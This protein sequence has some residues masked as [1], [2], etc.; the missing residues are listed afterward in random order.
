MEEFLMGVI[1]CFSVA[2]TILAY[3]FGYWKGKTAVPQT[4]GMKKPH[5]PKYRPDNLLDPISPAHQRLER[6]LERKEE[7]DRE[8]GER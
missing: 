6:A 7:E 3:K 5:T 4:L 8:E 1:L 2:C